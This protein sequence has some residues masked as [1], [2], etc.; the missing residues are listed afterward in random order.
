MTFYNDNRW[1]F[2]SPDNYDMS[3][4]RNR[5][6]V[7]GVWVCSVFWYRSVVRFGKSKYYS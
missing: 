3:V 5:E 4:Y 6:N 7:W 1:H 2:P